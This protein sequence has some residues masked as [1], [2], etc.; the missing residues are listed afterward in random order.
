M[1]IQQLQSDVESM[2]EWLEL[3]DIG[4][5]KNRVGEYRKTFATIDEH[6]KK[7]TVNE[8]EKSLGFPKQADNFHD[9]SELI[10]I[11]QH[12]KEYSP[13]LSVTEFLRLRWRLGQFMAMTCLRIMRGPRE[14][15]R[16]S[17]FLR[18]P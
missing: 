15:V 4:I 6:I 8:L 9:A 2:C 7:G 14:R 16:H 5:E 3:L 13:L 1:V 17:A 10:L 18:V 11:S 12:L